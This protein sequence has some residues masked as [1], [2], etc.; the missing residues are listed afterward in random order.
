MTRRYSLYRQVRHNRDRDIHCIAALSVPL[1]GAASLP[2]R[3]E[4]PRMH[5]KSNVSQG[6][7]TSEFVAGKRK[8]DIRPVIGSRTWSS[9]ERVNQA[10]DADAK[11]STVAHAVRCIQRPVSLSL[12]LCTSHAKYKST[13]RA[14]HHRTAR[15]YAYAILHGRVICVSPAHRGQPG[16]ASGCRLYISRTIFITLGH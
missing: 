13:S 14:P 15:L 11:R 12:F 3:E 4:K 9:V 5:R 16:S 1:A 8:R 2:K 7:V 10:I 6:V